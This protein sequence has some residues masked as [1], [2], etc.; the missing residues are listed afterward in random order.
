LRLNNK[1]IYEVF[2]GGIQ[3][4]IHVVNR[5]DTLWQISRRYGVSINQIVQ[6]NQL[7]N[8][9]VLVVGQALVIPS[10]SGTHVVQRGESLW[11]IARRYGVSVQS[12]AEANQIAN[13]ALIYAGQV[14]IIP[15]RS[16]EV[17]GYITRMGPS[18]GQ[19]VDYTGNYLT[20]ASPFSYSIQP[21]GN[22]NMLN[23]ADVLAAAGR[24]AVLPM[25][26][27]TNFGETGF[28]SELANAVL[29]STQVQDRLL[30]NV[31]KTMRQKGYRALNIDFEYLYP[32]DREP[33]NQFLL[34]T[35]NR[36][37]P[38]GYVVSTALAPKTSADKTGLLYEA[39]DYPAHGRIVDFVILMTYEWGWVGGPPWAVAPIN[40]VRRVL[41]YA[42]TAIPRNKIMMG[43]PLYG[44]DW[45][46]PFIQGTTRAEIITPQEA[47]RRAARYGANIQYN[48][49]Y[50]APFFFYTDENGA[51]H[52]VWFED[53]RSVQAKYNVV[54]EYGLRGVSYWEL[55]LEFPQ[56]WYV[57]EDSFRISKLV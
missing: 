10:P 21:D 7:S 47:I 41:N 5:G 57:L 43:V 42:V 46:L 24:E 29:S 23:D 20:Y 50:Q 36:L 13:P 16:A 1:L 48:Y 3:V 49:L 2:I 9:D 33:Y 4:Q 8:N 17:N 19:I 15:R 35:V 53:A 26:V 39:H 11:A 52:E 37:R 38:E 25:M 40:E 45:K 27:I 44:Y 56:N 12:I 22:L 6:A 31:M 54:K 30:D 34:R 28:N 14:L 32:R 18:G 55:N 51:T